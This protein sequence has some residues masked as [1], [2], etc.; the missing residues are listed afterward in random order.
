MTK[1]A[2]AEAI[3]TISSIVPKGSS[4][5]FDYPDE[6]TYTLEAG[7][8]AKKQVALAAGANEKILASYSYSELEKLL[9]DSNFVIYEH[10]IPNEITYRYFKKYNE[11]NPEHPVTGFDNV[12]YCL[13]V[14]K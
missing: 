7:D 12:N 5:V 13:E 2:L 6:K 1:E 11:S 9:D 14:K 10:L 4:I 8:R 3:R